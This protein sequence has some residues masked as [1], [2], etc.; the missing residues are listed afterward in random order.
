V[1]AN[2]SVSRL[3]EQ[4]IA[5]RRHQPAL[6]ILRHAVARPRRQGCHQSIGERILRSGNVARASRQ[7]RDEPAVRLARD[8][9]DGALRQFICAFIALAL[10]PSHAHAPGMRS[11]ALRR[12]RTKQPGSVPPTPMQHR[13]TAA[14]GS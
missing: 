5:R 14:R 8:G 2:L 9:L 11:V 6:R 4:A 3:V 1:I 7:Q 10:H 13:A 12:R